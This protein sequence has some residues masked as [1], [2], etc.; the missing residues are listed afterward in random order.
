LVTLR[1][2]FTLAPPQSTPNQINLL[3]LKLVRFT[4]TPVA[5]TRTRSCEQL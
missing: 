4:T 2:G 1:N 3:S 5:S